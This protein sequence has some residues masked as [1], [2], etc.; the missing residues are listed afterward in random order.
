MWSDPK[1]GSTYTDAQRNEMVGNPNY[2]KLFSRLVETNPV[3]EPVEAVA[4]SAKAKKDDSTNSA[5]VEQDNGN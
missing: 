3:P 2:N 4:K 1:T 5:A